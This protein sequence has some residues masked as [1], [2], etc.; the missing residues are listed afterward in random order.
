MLSGIQGISKKILS[1]VLAICLVLATVASGIVSQAWADGGV[2]AFICQKDGGDNV[3]VI[4][5]GTDNPNAGEYGTVIKAYS[6]DLTTFTSTTATYRMGWPWIATAG[7]PA[8]YDDYAKVVKKV[9][10]DGEV[11]LTYMSG[12]F[13]VFTQCTEFDFTGLVTPSYT[14]ANISS[15][16]FRNIPVTNDVTFIFGEKNTIT[17][18]SLSAGTTLYRKYDNVYSIVFP[19]VIPQGAGTYYTI[20]PDDCLL[21]PTATDYQVSLP[22]TSFIFDSAINQPVSAGI[23]VTMK[24]YP[25]IVMPSTAY[26]LSFQKQNSSTDEW[27][28][29]IN[30][31]GIGHY[32]VRAATTL[33]A[34]TGGYQT[35]ATDYTEFDITPG[36]TLNLYSDASLVTPVSGDGLNLSTTTD[37]YVK[38]TTALSGLDGTNE[39]KVY[40]TSSDTTK[41]SVG[42]IAKVGDYQSGGCVYKITLN[43]IT[44]GAADVSIWGYTGTVTT[45]AGS[46]GT[47]TTVLPVSTEVQETTLTFGAGAQDVL[48]GLVV[49]GDTAVVDLAYAGR[50][51]ETI[52][53]E[54]II[55]E[56][57]TYA[58]GGSSYTLVTAS[59]DL[60]T[61][62]L[63]V[64]PESL[65]SATSR[66]GKLKVTVPGVDMYG[67]TSIEIDVT[68]SR[69][70]PTTTLLQSDNR[71]LP[72]PLELKPGDIREITLAYTGEALLIDLLSTTDSAIAEITDVQTNL[73]GKGAV[74][75]VTARA[76]STSSVML[77]FRVGSAEPDTYMSLSVPFTVKVSK[78]DV[79]L[80]VNPDMLTLQAG[81]ADTAS[82]SYEGDGA[83]TAVSSDENVATATYD[84]GTKKLSVVALALG[85]ATVTV[86]AAATPTVN[87]AEATLQVTVTAADPGSQD[88]LDI[89]ALTET[90]TSVTAALDDT[91]VAVSADGSDVLE[92]QLWVG[93]QDRDTLATAA[94]AAEAVLAN[95]SSTQSQ[96]D[97]AATAL[98]TALATFEAAKAYGS[99]PLYPPNAAWVRLSG[100]GR[101][102]TMEKIVT[103][104]GA[105]TS[106]DTTTVIVAT[107]EN[108]PDALAATGLAGV[109]GA[110]VVLTAPDALSSQ[111]RAVITSLA[112]DAIYIVGGTSAVSSGVEASLKSL[113]TD[114]AKVIRAS[115]ASRNATA[116]DIYAKGG[117]AW[118]TTAI[119]ACGTSFAD[120]LSISPYAYAE[121]A[122]VFLASPLTGLDTETTATLK[123]AIGSG[124][125]THL[126]IVG[127]TAAVPDTVKVQLGYLSTDIS[128]FT[129]LGGANRYETSAIIAAH[130]ERA[131]ASLGFHR[132]AVATGANFPDALAGG[133]FAGKLGTVLLLA[134]D[135][136][137]GRSQIGAIIAANRQAIG[138]GH[139][140]GGEAVVLPA[141]KAAL[142]A[143]SA[144][145]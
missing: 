78:S 137:A 83:V 106:L 62:K 44:V 88:N 21:S 84:E 144:D 68:V 139:V 59:Y 26:T 19:S 74:I 15:N 112:P 52:N 123:D 81:E 67:E 98:N 29:N 71:P 53:A 107:G 40:A 8:I 33:S 7:N 65:V 94:A 24:E 31:T 97:A 20:K 111:A 125:I 104:S 63:S 100:A 120:A 54:E 58:T 22:A 66:T 32:R 55:V 77:T 133:A 127:G 91:T 118:G 38:C 108:F 96:I 87:A 79:A 95:P 93:Q 16:M 126:I 110:P 85:V 35:G 119:I 30:R 75:T 121:K 80:V 124:A 57:P 143:A 140:L 102:D 109:K 13:A 9:V 103:D 5:N 64:T 129:R 69:I 34:A 82:V 43:P 86:S 113:V 134:D 47:F 14:E 10:V 48:N 122:P 128:T 117:G 114:P 25:E 105:F 18:L 37:I 142:E 89:A 61:G 130:I 70:T 141:L 28:L 50:D 45:L 138:F 12:M 72:Q 51:P 11:S 92:T 56:C 23:T 76:A 41:L 17:A 36:G 2:Y 99:L 1:C 4:K 46:V 49:R 6:Q 39:M 42:A 101:Y 145:N 115:G 73:D 3:L 116:L 60:V 90:I 27:G 135:S 131:S 136:A 132:I